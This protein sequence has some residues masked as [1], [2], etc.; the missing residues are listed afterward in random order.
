MCVGRGGGEVR[1]ALVGGI[2][3]DASC[4]RDMV[5]DMVKNDDIEQCA[6]SCLK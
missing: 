5:Y 4:Q 3:Y 2:I 1:K 6:M